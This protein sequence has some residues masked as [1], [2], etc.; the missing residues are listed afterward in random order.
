MEV[1]S[2]A[3]WF[4]AI[5]TIGAVVV[6]LFVIL[7]EKYKKPELHSMQ[8]MLKETKNGATI[9][10]DETEFA[11]WLINNSNKIYMIRWMGVRIS[12]QDKSARGRKNESLVLDGKGFFEDD[13]IYVGPNQT[14]ELRSIP[15]SFIKKIL[16]E[17]IQGKVLI[18][19]FIWNDI[20]G[21]EIIKKYKY[22]TENTNP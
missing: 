5:G 12:N 18:I 13:F 1:G 3:D 17:N 4:S 9:F 22:H 15:F 20:N 7:S 14:I 10:K 11:F 2:L 21:K 6:S 8:R 16:P 19:E